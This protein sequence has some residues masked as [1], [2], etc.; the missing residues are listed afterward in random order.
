ML[1]L[2]EGRRGVVELF[3]GLLAIIDNQKFIYLYWLLV[4][5]LLIKLEEAI[6]L[7]RKQENRL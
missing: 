4:L 3:G 6:G 2:E 7:R 5:W 1:F